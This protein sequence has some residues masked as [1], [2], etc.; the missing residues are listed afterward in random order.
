MKYITSALVYIFLMLNLAAPAMAYQ[1]KGD[2]IVLSTREMRA[3]LD[4]DGCVVIPHM[5]LKEDLFKLREAAWSEG[6][7][8]G[9]AEGYQA[10]YAAGL[11]AAA[12]KKGAV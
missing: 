7:K 2:H 11:A 8:Y 9:A 6:A 10:G 3:C 1:V 4:G 12:S 5:Q